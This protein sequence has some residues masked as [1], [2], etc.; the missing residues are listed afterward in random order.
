MWSQAWGHFELQA[1]DQ[2]PKLDIIP[3]NAK[4]K[5]RK[6]RMRI[7]QY[8]RLTAKHFLP[9][10]RERLP[11]LSGRAR[12]QAH[13]AVRV[14]THWQKTLNVPDHDLP[15]VSR[16]KTFKPVRAPLP[17]PPSARYKKSKTATTTTARSASTASTPPA[18]APGQEYMSESKM[19]NAQQEPCAIIDTQAQGK[20]SETHESRTPRRSQRL[21]EK[22]NTQDVAADRQGGNRD[23][24]LSL[25]H[26][27]EFRDFVYDLSDSDFLDPESHYLYENT[28][29]RKLPPFV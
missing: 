13:D 15:V 7:E 18:G 4:N 6:H 26:R 16:N 28:Q 25:A 23:L 14:F 11:L 29:P 8:K 2:I 17:I 20:K 12:E 1:W 21:A 19:E 22:Y 5:E 24:D 3:I 27:V 10:L 9:S